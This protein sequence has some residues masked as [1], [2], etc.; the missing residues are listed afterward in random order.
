MRWQ[1]QTDVP[2]NAKGRAQARELIPLLEPLNLSKIISSD[3]SRALETAQ[4]VATSLSCPLQSHAGFRELGFGEAEGMTFDEIGHKFGAEAQVRV[5]S[6]DDFD[7]DFRL[8]GGESKRQMLARAHFALGELL[9]TDHLN[10]QEQCPRIGLATHG[11]LI[12]TFLQESGLKD[13]AQVTIPNGSLFLFEYHIGVQKLI[14]LKR[15]T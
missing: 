13:R 7:L 11:G 1:G 8:P 15:I 12:R 10:N 14:Y 4:I 5:R 2:L 9:D 6:T 3:L